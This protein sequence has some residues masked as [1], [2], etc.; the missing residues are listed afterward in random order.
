MTV[1][2]RSGKTSLGET[3][4]VFR[5]LGLYDRR[6]TSH[7]RMG[8]F[9]VFP[10][11][12]SQSRKI[13]IVL[14]K[15]C[16]GRGMEI[17]REIAVSSFSTTAYYSVERSTFSRTSRNV[18]TAFD[19]HVSCSSHVDAQ[20][21]AFF[22]D[23]RA[24]CSTV[25]SNR[26]CIICMLHSSTWIHHTRFRRSRG[27]TPSTSGENEDAGVAAYTDRICGCDR[28]HNVCSRRQDVRLR[29]PGRKVRLK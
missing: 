23:P 29:P 14:F 8:D 21:A 24:E 2:A 20:L 16:R 26:M 15:R 25:Q 9:K 3:E 4:W 27:P 12:F 17:V 18:L 10:Y 22:I 19:V 13:K 11:S 7:T 6:Q 5:S 1:L 28:R